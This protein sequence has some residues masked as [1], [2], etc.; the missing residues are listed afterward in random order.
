MVILSITLTG[1]RIIGLGSRPMDK[2]HS[3]RSIKTS[4]AAELF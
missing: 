3:A 1:I 2:F 4:P